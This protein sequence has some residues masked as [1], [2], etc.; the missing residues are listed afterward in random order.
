MYFDLPADPACCRSSQVPGTG[1]P[2]PG[3]KAGAHRPGSPKD[4]PG[5]HPR[6]SPGLETSGLRQAA[7]WRARQAAPDD[8]TP[9]VRGRLASRAVA[10]WRRS[11]PAAR[12]QRTSPT[13]TGQRDFSTFATKQGGVR[14]HQAPVQANCPLQK[15][16]VGM[17]IGSWV[18]FLSG[19][20]RGSASC[21]PCWRENLMLPARQTFRHALPVLLWLVPGT[22]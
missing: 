5:Q 1:R 3:R 21:C 11:P 10:A 14:A 9:G 18:V 15:S 20:K 13:A 4:P 16:T 12:P 6:L 8:W 2:R 22:P 7:P 19:A 17:P